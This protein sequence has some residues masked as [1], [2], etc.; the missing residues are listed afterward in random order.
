MKMTVSRARTAS[1]S[2]RPTF[3]RS[4]GTPQGSEPAQRCPVERDRPELQLV[5]RHR[6]EGT[7]EAI[8]SRRRRASSLHEEYGDDAVGQ[9]NA[10]RAERDEPMF[11]L[12]L[13]ITFIPT[14]G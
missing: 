1:R 11:C 10:D 12:A 9:D 8:R 5:L 13:I 14:F 4:Q 2:S 3:E 7:G 6:R